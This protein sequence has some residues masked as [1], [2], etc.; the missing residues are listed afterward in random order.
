MMKSVEPTWSATQDGLVGDLGV[1]DD[2]AVGVLGPEG[3]D[4]LGPEPLVDRAVAPPQQERRLLAVGLG[5]AAEVAAGVP[6][7]HL[8]EAVAH[9]DAGVAAEVLVGEEDHL[10][11]AAGRADRGLAAAERPLEHGAGVGRGADGAAVAR[12]RTP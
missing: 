5:E 8:V 12:R 1:H 3:G 4:V 11:A 6:Q 10:V 7:P 2:D 9:G